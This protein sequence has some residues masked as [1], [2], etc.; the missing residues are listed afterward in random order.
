MSPKNNTQ[1]V[2]GGLIQSVPQPLA[3]K[4]SAERS[5]VPLSC[6]CPPQ[7]AWRSSSWMVSIRSSPLLM[8]ATT[9]ADGSCCVVR[10]ALD[11]VY[12]CRTSFDRHYSS[13]VPN[14]H[15]TKMHRRMLFCRKIAQPSSHEELHFIAEEKQTQRSTTAL[16]RKVEIGYVHEIARSTQRH[17]H[18]KRRQSAALLQTLVPAIRTA[19]STRFL[20]KSVFLSILAFMLLSGKCKLP[21]GLTLSNG[22]WIPT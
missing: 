3:M 4:S 7:L 8:Q 2:L 9:S 20:L 12:L 17:H 21:S 22:C 19:E 11:C 14:V 10:R 18:H 15:G 1:I 5:S 16:R 13:A 6:H